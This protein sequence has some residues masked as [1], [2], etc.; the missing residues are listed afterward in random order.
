M[1][2]QFNRIF[3]L[4]AL[5]AIPMLGV[6]GLAR[7]EEEAKPNILV[8]MGSFTDDLHAAFM[9]IKVAEALQ[10]RGADV[11]IFVNLEAVRLADTRQPNDLMWGQAHGTFAQHYDA[12]VEGGGK[13]AVCP[14]CAK[15]AGLEADTL[16]PGAAILEGDAL[17]DLFLKADKVIDY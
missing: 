6:T 9:G 13:I 4:T 1:M 3:L 17:G 2:K 15:A 16:R 5:L 11:T 10:A 12:F 7:A 14:H 8:T